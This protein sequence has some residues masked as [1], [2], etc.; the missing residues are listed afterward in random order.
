M[1]HRCLLHFSLPKLVYLHKIAPKR[2]FHVIAIKCIRES[3]CIVSL[4]SLDNEKFYVYFSRLLSL[5]LFWCLSM[6]ESKAK[7][8]HW[9]IQVLC[10]S[11]PPKNRYQML[12]CRLEWEQ[13]CANDLQSPNLVMFG[14]PSLFHI[15]HNNVRD[16]VWLHRRLGGSF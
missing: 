8:V 7:E 1:E 14:S 9:N 5:V 3:I 6:P 10:S 15:L 4:R 2:A 16:R 13:Q 12:C 11:K